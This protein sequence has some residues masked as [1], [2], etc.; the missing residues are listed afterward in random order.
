MLPSTSSLSRLRVVELRQRLKSLGLPTTGLKMELLRRLQD[1]LDASEAEMEH[2]ADD[3]KGQLAAQAEGSSNAAAMDSSPSD[4]AVSPRQ[5]DERERV[6]QHTA[7]ALQ[8]QRASLLDRSVPMRKQD[9]AGLATKRIEGTV[10]TSRKAPGDVHYGAV[11]APP[12][13][14]SAHADAR[15]MTV[16]RKG[17]SKSGR[18]WRPARTK[19]FSS[20]RAVPQLRTSWDQKMK[21]KKMKQ[22]LQAQQKALLDADKV[23]RDRQRLE[24][25]NK[26]KQRQR[27]IEKSVVVQVIKNPAKLKKLKKKQ[28][29]NIRKSDL[30]APADGKSGH[31]TRS[32]YSNDSSGRALTGK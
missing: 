24:R 19:R 3:V 14:L 5:A 11:F 31:G 21:A 15:S 16:R 28:L 23:L 9:A 4:S 2:L 20:I 12:G 13:K 30:A 1:H 29:R 18:S 25:E 6:R 17:I 27:N 32:E 22:A 26:R 7:A 10:R 8:D